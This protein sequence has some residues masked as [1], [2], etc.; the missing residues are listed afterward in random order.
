MEIEAPD[1]APALAK[2]SS[3]PGKNFTLLCK[4]EEIEPLE[5]SSNDVIINELRVY[6][7]LKGLVTEL[8]CPIQFYK[9]NSH[10]IPNMAKI[11]HMLFSITASSVPSECVFST[12]G[13]LIS[14]KRTRLR[15]ALAEEL[16]MLSKNK[17]DR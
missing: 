16:L 15:P 3:I 10:Q 17:F 4:E 8:S 7:T 1:A 11:S 6:L 12:A 2:Q 9:L 5:M 14:K 13:E